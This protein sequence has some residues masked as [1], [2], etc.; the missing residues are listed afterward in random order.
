MA[1]LQRRQAPLDAGYR[2]V[3]RAGQLGQRHRKPANEISVKASKISAKWRKK[4]AITLRLHNGH[5]YSG[6]RNGASNIYIWKMK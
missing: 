4:M 6:E 5:Q 2:V 1:V 3:L